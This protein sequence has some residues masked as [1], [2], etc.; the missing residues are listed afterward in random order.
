MQLQR[1]ALSAITKPFMN[2]TWWN[3]NCM[4]SL[5]CIDFELNPTIIAINSKEALNNKYSNKKLPSWVVISCFNTEGKLIMWG[6]KNYSEWCTFFAPFSI[7]FKKWSEGHNEII[8]V[9]ISS[10]IDKWCSWKLFQLVLLCAID[11]HR[12]ILHAQPCSW[13]TQWVS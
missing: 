2:K 11:N 5:F 7:I 3:W 8:L 10:S 9:Y 6:F 13:C 4:L 1:R 12:I